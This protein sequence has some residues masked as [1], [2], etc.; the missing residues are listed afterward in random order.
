MTTMPEPSPV[1]GYRCRG[2]GIEDFHGAKIFVG[3]CG[4]KVHDSRFL[5]AVKDAPILFGEL[6]TDLRSA[7]VGVHFCGPVVEVYAQDSKLND[8]TVVGFLAQALDRVQH[9]QCEELI[10]IV[11]R[12]RAIARGT[13]ERDE[14]HAPAASVA[15]EADQVEGQ[16]ADAYEMLLA[17]AA[18]APPPRPAPRSWSNW[19]EQLTAAGIDERILAIIRQAVAREADRVR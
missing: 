10:T 3:A 14:V 7:V 8:E 19:L 4:L 2:C 5:R 11:T 1:L 9:P 17:T 18:G 13:R 6:S 12:W 15:A 16:I